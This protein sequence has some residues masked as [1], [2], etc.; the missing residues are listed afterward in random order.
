MSKINEEKLQAGIIFGDN[1]NKE[2]I[3]MPGSEIGCKDPLCILE[4]DGSRTD[5]TISEALNQITRL[6]LKPVEH[7]VYG[8]K[9]Y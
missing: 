3:Y 5:L 2:Y 1:I 7:P 4:K 8:K 9:Y 6:S